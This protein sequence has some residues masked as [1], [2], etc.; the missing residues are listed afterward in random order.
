MLQKILDKFLSRWELWVGGIAALAILV[1]VFIYSDHIAEWAGYGD[2]EAEDGAISSGARLFRDAV[3][4]VVALFG[5]GLAIA[6]ALN[7]DRQAKTGEERLLR[8][9][10]AT[11]AEL[12][13]KEIAGNPA[14]SARVSGMYIMEELAI[15]YPGRFLVSILKT[16]AAYIK[17]NAQI[18]ATPP[19][20]KGLIPDMPRLLGEDVITAFSVINRLYEKN[21]QGDI[22]KAFFPP[23]LDFSRVDFSHLDFSRTYGLRWFRLAGAN[24]SGA[25]LHDVNLRKATLEGAT[26][27]G[28]NLSYALLCGAFMY[29]AQ[30]QGA[31]LIGTH[32]Q[33][34][35]AEWQRADL[36]WARI[37]GFL[38]V[39]NWFVDC[40]ATDFMLSSIEKEPSKMEKGRMT[41][42]IW[43][44]PNSKLADIPEQGINDWDLEECCR[45]STSALVGAFRNFSER[46]E[47]PQT[48]RG[49]SFRKAAVKL[50]D[51]G[52][53][54]PDF[55]SDWRKWLEELKSSTS[56][57][58]T[59]R[60]VDT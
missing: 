28:A 55:P 26:L 47:F 13:T 56:L 51:D 23:I 59:R 43:R 12:M 38:D 11:A 14:I 52:K 3:V 36:S 17:D 60:V 2:M 6:R 53:L 54:P 29:G 16:L 7:L 30:L 19:L 20:V 27:H 41:H 8:E 40:Y 44:H 4:L 21:E 33:K 5:I 35:A 45:V 18:T 9:R 10:F 58:I 1:L 25:N 31:T 34:P 39:T 15:A 32:L 42:R 37:H 49:E 22:P 24:F 50:L 46:Y 57:G 48:P